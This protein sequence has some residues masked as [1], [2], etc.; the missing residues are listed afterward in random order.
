MKDTFSKHTLIGV[1]QRILK[2]RLSIIFWKHFYHLFHKWRQTDDNSTS[3][4]RLQ[5][6]GKETFASVAEVLRQ[7]Q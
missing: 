2:E 3:G 7:A 1:K 5:Q 6:F 4:R